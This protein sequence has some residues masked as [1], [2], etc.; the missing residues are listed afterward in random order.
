MSL[1]T[2]C[3]LQNHTMSKGLSGTQA[4]DVP[5]ILMSWG[6]LTPQLNGPTVREHHLSTF[7]CLVKP[8]F[9]KL[10]FCVGVVSATL[11]FLPAPLLLGDPAPVPSGL[12][13]MALKNTS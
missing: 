5:K 11:R 2:D 12:K 7:A 6:T 8:N 4:P 1:T 13:P 10:L 3:I 9:I